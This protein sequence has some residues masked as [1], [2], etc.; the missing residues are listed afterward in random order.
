[1]VIVSPM[2]IVSKVE[3]L[4]EAFFLRETRVGTCP[5]HIVPAHQLMAYGRT[6][7]SK[8]QFFPKVYY[9]YMCLTYGNRPLPNRTSS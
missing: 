8:C 3:L 1:M 4:D 6:A 5:Q 2:E 9:A 7:S